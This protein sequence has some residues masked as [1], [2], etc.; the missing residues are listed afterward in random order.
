MQDEKLA[1]DLLVGAEAIADFT[2]LEVR[3]VYHQAANLGL[4]KLGRLL[5]GSKKNLKRVL[6]GEAA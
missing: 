1:D 2:G 4:K 3:Q 6:T 5:T